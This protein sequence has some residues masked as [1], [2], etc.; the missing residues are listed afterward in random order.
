MKL[1]RWALIAEI[2]GAIAIVISLIFVGFQIQQGTEQTALN[3]KAIQASIRQSILH[4][5]LEGLYLYM[6][7]PFLNKRI[8][9]EPD[10]EVQIRAQIV[11]FVRM[12]EILWLQYRDGLLDE[13]TWLSYR[14]PLTNV[15]FQ[16]Q[17]GRDVW[18]GEGYS[19]AFREYIDAWIGSLNLP[20]KD[21]VLP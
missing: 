15:V 14:Q 5:D 6:D 18:G 13:E 17:I 9:I 10:E 1:E 19:P 20:D 2:A 4:E 3:T 21:T 11:A 16:S 12:R 7:H 8:N